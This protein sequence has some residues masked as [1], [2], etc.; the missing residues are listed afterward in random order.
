[1]A[2]TSTSD[3]LEPFVIAGAGLAGSLMANFLARR[4]YPVVCVEARPDLRAHTREEGRSINL[5]LS[6]RGLN[7]L[8]ALGLDTEARALCTPMYGRLVHDEQGEVTMQNYGRPGQHINSVSRR[9]LNAMLLDAAEATG[10]V[11]FHFE[12]RIEEVRL[13]E[14]TL[15]CKSA[16]K[17]KRERISGRLLIG[18]DGAFSMVREAIQKSGRVD[19]AQSFLDYGYKELTIPPNPDGTHRMRND[20]LHIWPRHRFMLIA[21]PNTDGSFTCTLFLPWEGETSFA[22]LSA[23]NVRGFFATHFPDALRVIDDLEGDF[24]S[25]PTGSMVTISTSPWHHGGDAVLIGDAAHAIVPFYGQGMNAAFE[26]CYCLDKLLNQHAGGDLSELLARFS[27]E[28]KPNADAISELAMQNFVEMR[29]SV[30]KPTYLVRKQVEAI[31]Q[32]LFPNRYVPLYS[33]ISFTN[34]PYA[35][36]KARAERQDELIDAVLGAS[37]LL[38]TAGVVNLV[39]KRL[40]GEDANG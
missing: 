33:M 28:R 6:E 39:R 12:T 23:D 5:A 25:N 17:R 29:S 24:A 21:L 38:G 35:A 36:A 11:R 7:A 34:I 9:A 32:M 30:A 3:R 27:D 10:R 22:S 19:Y 37:G 26:D 2:A 31:A 13:S 14:R 1:M 8:R 15:V 40:S 18:A 4:G 16:G 20:G